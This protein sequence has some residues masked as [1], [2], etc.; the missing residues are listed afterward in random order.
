VSGLRV[1]LGCGSTV[2]PG[3]EN[4]DSSPGVLLSRA[5]ALR[6][7][8]ARVRVLNA[9]QASARFPDGIVRFDVRRGLPWPD[10]SVQA[11]Y[12]SHMIEH[13][14]RWQGL[15]L[16]RE[17]A[18]VMAPGAVL[19]FATPDLRAIVGE[20]L[21]GDA[22]ES[23]TP[24]D[25]LMRRLN[26]YTDRRG[27][28]AQRLVHKLV[29]AAPHQWVY[30]SA[31]LAELLREGGLSDPVERSFRQG[32]LPDLDALEHRPDSIFLEARKA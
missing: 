6:G 25:E 9:D 27:S 12:S 31:S 29:S 20:Y 30:D 8:L 10:G 4:V 13:L 32:E 3:W 14:S 28:V 16:V 7:A 11:V 21:D 15:E 23:A 22:G 24:A 19:R 1:H 26:T 18:R 2:V 5:P 17:C